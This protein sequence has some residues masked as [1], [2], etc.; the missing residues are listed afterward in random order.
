MKVQEGE[1]GREPHCTQHRRQNTV[2][3][4]GTGAVFKERDGTLTM[5]KQLHKFNQRFK[6]VKFVQLAVILGALARSTLVVQWM[7]TGGSCH[8]WGKPCE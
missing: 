1:A 8:R 3:G 2:A 6:S 4:E 5:L 7:L